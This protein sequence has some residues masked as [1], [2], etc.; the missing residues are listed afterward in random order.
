MAARLAVTEV[1]GL[2]VLLTYAGRTE[3]AFAAKKPSGD[4]LL[5]WFLALG[6]VSGICKEIFF[7]GLAKRFCG[8]VMGEMTAL[9]LFNV[10]FAMLDWHNYGYSFVIGLVWIWAY[11]K[12]GRLLAPMIAHGGAGIISAFYWMA[13]SR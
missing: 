4:E 6:L 10:M 2:L 5:L 9:L 7:R 3:M 11:R 12:T 13:V 8:P 1:L